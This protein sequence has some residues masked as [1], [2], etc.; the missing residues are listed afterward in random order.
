MSNPA[1]VPEHDPDSPVQYLIHSALRPVLDQWLTSHGF[2]VDRVAHLEREGDLPLY[3]VGIGDDL[4]PS[5]T[6][7]VAGPAH[8]IPAEAVCWTCRHPSARHRVRRVTAESEPE[9]ELECSGGC[10]CSSPL[11]VAFPAHPSSLIPWC[12]CGHTARA[13]VWNH[14][15]YLVGSCRASGCT[16]VDWTEAQTSTPLGS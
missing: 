15:D 1:S 11:S 8:S 6:E 3:L 14:G 13:H 4:M 5:R 12:T 10:P 16:C 7:T 9:P 2:T